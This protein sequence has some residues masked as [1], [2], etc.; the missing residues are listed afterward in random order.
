MKTRIVCDVC[1]YINLAI[2]KAS[3]TDKK[4]KKETI[5]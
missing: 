3:N 2:G 5:L 4:K 1:D